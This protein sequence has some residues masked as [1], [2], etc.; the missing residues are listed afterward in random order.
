MKVLQVIPYMETKYGGPVF[1]T[2]M[3][4]NLLNIN[5]IENKILTVDSDQARKHDQVVVY[6]RSSKL[7]FFSIDLLL[8]AHKEVRICSHILVHGV[9]TFFTFWVF[10]LA[11]VYRKK[12]F[13]RPAG[14]LDK[15]SIFSDSSLKSLARIFYLI[16]VGFFL[17]LK[18]N[19]IIFN[20]TKEKKNSIFGSK[21][22]SILLPNGIIPEMTN[23]EFSDKKFSKP[24]KLFFMGRLHPIKGIDL[25]VDAINTLDMEVRSDIELIVAGDGDKNFIE[26]IKNKS[27]S[28]IKYIGHIDGDIKYE[29][30]QECDIYIQPSRTEGL[31]NS[32]LEAMFCHVAIITTKDSGLASELSYN[33]A[34][35]IINYDVDELAVAILKLINST[36][37]VI[38]YKRNSFN[39]VSEFYNFEK[40]IHKY[41]EVFNR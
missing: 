4:S 20:S 38:N 41:I 35:E 21:K 24:K 7:W 17:Y 27:C 29:Y 36:G 18:S 16:T 13:L 34:A 25:L 9:Y 37:T 14:M 23:V 8:N 22:K 15:D 28:S 2:T 1:V 6:K 40:N 26:G 33:K 5:N 19:R 11:L 10:I 30:L 12:I 3:I 32:M 39:F 31:S